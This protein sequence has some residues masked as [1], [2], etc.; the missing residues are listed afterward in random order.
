MFLG[1]QDKKYYPVKYYSIG[2]AFGTS[3]VLIVLI[4]SQWF[5]LNNNGNINTSRHS[6]L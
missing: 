6:K 3:D 1:W 4:I 2:I 5:G